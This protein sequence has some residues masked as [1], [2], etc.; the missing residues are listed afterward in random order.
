MARFR[1][2]GLYL[3]TSEEMSRGRSTVEIVRAALRAG[4]RLVQ[5]REKRLDQGPFCRLAE[6]V[7]AMTAESD[8]LL[9]I[10]D[11]LDV[12]MAVGA[13]GVH[14]GQED[15]PVPHARRLVPDM[16]VGASTHS[17]QQ[18]AAAEQ[19]G[20]S[21]VNIGPLFP[22]GTKPEHASGLG[23]EGLRRIGPA[24]TIPFTVMGGIK[25]EHVPA[26]VRAGARTLAVVTAVT[27]ADDPESAARDLLACIRGSL[28]ES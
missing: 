10:N 18:A 21:Y 25:A 3:V 15:L 2:A 12:A 11:R 20:A 28:V 27:A 4:V 23:V 26:L 8:A 17:A 14:L 13:D 9:I 1:Q 22:T 7:R 6:K 16:I 24:V 19:A 5:L